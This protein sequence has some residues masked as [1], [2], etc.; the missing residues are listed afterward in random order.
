[1]ASAGAIG[2]VDVRVTE[3][4]DKVMKMLTPLFEKQ[5]ALEKVGG[6]TKLWVGVLL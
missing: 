6:M 4:Q 1:M 2:R 3:L 5:N